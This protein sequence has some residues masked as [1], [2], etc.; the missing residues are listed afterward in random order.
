VA[1]EV[2]KAIDPIDVVEADEL[3]VGVA[4]AAKY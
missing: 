4:G 3:L 2:M 1:P